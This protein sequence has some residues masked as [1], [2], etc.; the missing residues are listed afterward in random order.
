M[1][2]FI[3]LAFTCLLISCTQH[4]SPEIETVLKQAGN[5]RSELEQV[6]K[7]Y[8]KTPA[9]SLK[10]KAAEFLIVNMPDKYSEYY[11]APWNDVTTVFLRWS[12][13]SD[14]QKVL[15]TYGI[16][17]PVVRDDV[18]YIT[19]DYLINNIELSFKVWQEQPWGKHISFDAFC[20]EIL[21]YRVDNEPLENWRGKVLAS[22]ADINRSFKEQPYLT[23]VEACCIINDLLP[24][25][26]M[27]RDFS[28]M[29]YSMTMATARGSCDE[30]TN[31]AIFVMRALGIPV[32]KDFTPKWPNRNVGHSWNTV[33]DSIGRHITFMGAETN[34]GYFGARLLKGKIYRR[35][36]AIWND[37]TDKNNSPSVF[38]DFN[39][40]DV[41]AEY[42]ETIN[43]EI[44]VKYQPNNNSQYAYLSI[45][46][47]GRWN[48]VG[49]GA[50]NNNTIHFGALG[51]NLLYLPVYSENESEI[52][53]NYPFWLDEEGVVKILEPDTI[54]LQDAKLLG[55]APSRNDRWRAR[56]LNGVFEGAN[57][58]DFSD[59]QVLHIIKEPQ[60]F[61]T[62]KIT[63]PN[64]FRYIRYVSPN[65]GLCD[66]AEIKFFGKSLKELKGTI[67][68]SP[69]QSVHEVYMMTPEKAF[70]ND[71][72]T[73]FEADKDNDGWI[74]MDLNEKQQITEIHYM[75]RNDGD[76]IIKGNVYELYYWKNKNW[77]LL[78][79]RTATEY[80]V[81]S[82]QMPSNALFYICNVSMKKD[83]YCAF[84][85][86]DGV[87]KW[88]RK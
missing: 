70:D 50:V 13:S 2:K 82:C 71:I 62:A 4:Y 26:K 25:F 45:P 15:D 61:N 30:Q 34:P 5:N 83:D 1:Q 32:T 54:H 20:E 14:I 7:H 76:G 44:P 53:A 8:S 88:L 51:K 40:I 41:T 31:L 3:I 55:V 11:D 39:G 86:K 58:S 16:G 85:I 23:T 37:I 42:E 17:E 67:I 78:G 24:R 75:P 80:D 46:G 21:P 18:K 81:L 79:K 19:A 87:Q 22:F 59:A 38:M 64:K 68:S 74:G 36:F 56:M 12:S 66:V 6:L 35:T 47:V 63:N 77:Q 28:S 48:I 84:I 52:P 72:L 49:W 43:V 33:T 27:D 65:N 69:H 57:M 60:T 29:N 9:D 73:F 10:L